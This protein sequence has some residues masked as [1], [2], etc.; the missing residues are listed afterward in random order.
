MIYKVYSIY[1]SKTEGYLQPFYQQTKGQAVR[2]FTEVVNDKSSQIGKY[3]EDYTLFE[4]GDFDD[5]N[6]KFSIY[7]TPKSVGVGIE[8]V[9]S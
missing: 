7:D 4:L 8:F 5:T 3:P 6:C 9:K 1:D 2:G